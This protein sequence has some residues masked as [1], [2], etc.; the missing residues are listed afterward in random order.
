MSFCGPWPFPFQLLGQEGFFRFFTVTFRAANYE[1]GI[2]PE[3]GLPLG[4][5]G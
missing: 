5:N 3:L 2:E 4:V 1:F